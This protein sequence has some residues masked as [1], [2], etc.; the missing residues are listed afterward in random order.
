MRNRAPLTISWEDPQRLAE[1]GR[2][3][4]GAEFLRKIVDGDRAR[5]DYLFNPEGV[6]FSAALCVLCV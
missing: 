3:L 2:G 4:S 6:M 1:A 5:H